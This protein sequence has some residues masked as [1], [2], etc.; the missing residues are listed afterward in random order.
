VRYKL[1]TLAVT[2]SFFIAAVPALA[3]DDTSSYPTTTPTVTTPTTPAETTETADAA[4]SD[5]SGTAGTGSSELAQTGGGD[6]WKLLAIGGVLA[7]G[8]SM[9]LVS[10]RRP[11]RNR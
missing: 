5:D 4:P 6:S 3:Q 7:I 8:S 2:A 11:R 1:L 9:L 10:M